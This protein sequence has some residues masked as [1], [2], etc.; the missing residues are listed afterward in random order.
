M[1]AFFKF[2]V[3]KG[4]WPLSLRPCF[5]QNEQDNSYIKWSVDKVKALLGD[6][7]LHGQLGS[8]V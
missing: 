4:K 7:E 8:P 1:A 2:R 5:W 6:P 3:G